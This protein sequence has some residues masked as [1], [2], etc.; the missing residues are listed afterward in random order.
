MTQPANSSS[1]PALNRARWV[2]T[3][4]GLAWTLLALRLVQLQW[5]QQDRLS[6][7][8]EQQREFDEEITAR[9]GDIVDRQGRLLATTLTLRSLYIVPRNISQSWTVAN[10][11]AGALDLDRD[12]LFEK[13]G[14][15]ADKHF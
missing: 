15:R 1:S 8:A 14:E 11:L 13:I 7:R 10:S 6:D 3:A 2:V 4:F 9:P 12:A 5:W